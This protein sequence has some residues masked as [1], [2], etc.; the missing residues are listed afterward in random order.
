MKGSSRPGKAYRDLYE[1]V[2]GR[3]PL[4]FPRFSGRLRAFALL[5]VSGTS[6]RTQRGTYSLREV[7]VGEERREDS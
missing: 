7:H 4:E 6:F 1:R 5:P 2:A 3:H